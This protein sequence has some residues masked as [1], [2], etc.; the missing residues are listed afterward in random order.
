MKVNTLPLK[1]SGV[2]TEIKIIKAELEQLTKKK[3]SKKKKIPHSFAELRGIW[4]GIPDFF[5]EEIKEAEIAG[6]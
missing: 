3:V 1:I 4:K 6:G 2:E 5:Y